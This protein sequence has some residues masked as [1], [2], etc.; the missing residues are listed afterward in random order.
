M[1]KNPFSF[2]WRIR[3]T[4]YILSY[5]TTMFL[6][7][8]LNFLSTS[9]NVSNIGSIVFMLFA[10]WF[11]LAQGAKRCHDL[12]NNG[13]WQIIPLY[14]LWLLFVKGELLENKYGK[15]PHQLI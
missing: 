15:N 11:L 5:T 1:F 10:Y 2:D 6:I 7:G 13:W 4:E 14:I 9:S 12:G 3:R 8:F